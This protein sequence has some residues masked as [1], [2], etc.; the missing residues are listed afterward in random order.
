MVLVFAAG[1]AAAQ[2]YSGQA[3][4]V[5]LS[6]EIAGVKQLTTNVTDTGDLPNAGGNISLTSVGVGLPGGIVTVGSSNSTAS[7]GIPG[8]NVN[9]SQSTAS[10]NNLSVG[11]LGNTITA[12]AVSSSTS[13]ICPGQV[14][15]GN[16]VITNLRINGAF[17]TIDGTP[18]QTIQ[19]L[20]GGGELLTVVI[21]ERIILPRSITVNALH[22]TLE[23]PLN[24]TRTDVI[25][26]SARSGINCLIAPSLDLYSG[27]G[28]GVRL[29]QGSATI[30]HLSTIIADTGWLP[31]P[32]G[33]ISTTTAGLG[34]SPILTTGTATSATEGGSPAGTSASEARVEELGVFIGQPTILLPDL[35]MLSA[36]VIESETECSCSLSVPTCSGDSNLV[37]LTASVLGIPVT[38]PLDFPPN[39][40]LVDLDLTGI[41]T[42]R[43]I[44]N[45]QQSAGPGDI[46]VNA[47]HIELGVI[48]GLLV[49]TDIIVAQSHSD[50]VCGIGPSSSEVSLSGRVLNEWDQGIGHVTVRV[51]DS[52]G[53]TH[54][55]LTNPMGYFVIKG[56][57]AGEVYIVEANSKRYI[58]DPITLNMDDDIGNFE[59]R[60]AGFGN[61]KK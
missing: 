58:F 43:I 21:N 32:G 14:P 40:V 20:L 1:E 9:S 36:D 18:N 44:A 45:E 5:G 41:L 16:S 37:G 15:S 49:N 33:S 60:P 12:D 52:T 22:I 4:A 24:L 53:N 23:D 38:I 55:A 61:G 19:I 30:P 7:A 2:T 31:T 25:V 27:R 13:C 48:S 46:T 51:M 10:V 57:R 17:V 42:L 3:Y 59:I 35:L 50:I 28:T 8:G 56:L 54:I 47:L 26:A 11:L 29:V 34:L 6:S 39:T